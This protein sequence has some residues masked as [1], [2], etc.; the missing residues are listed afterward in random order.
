MTAVAAPSSDPVRDNGEWIAALTGGGPE[1]ER[2]T[3]TLR[4]TLRRALERAPGPGSGLDLEETTQEAVLQVLSSIERFRGDSAFTTWAIGIAIRTAYTELRRSSVRA[5]RTVAFADVAAE[6]DE[7][8]ARRPTDPATDAG[9]R[10][11]WAALDHAI[12]NALTDRQ[13][14]AILAEL[15]GIPT[16]EIA[17]QLQTNQNALYKLVHDARKKLRRDLERRGFDAS[18]LRDLAAKGASA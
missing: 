13:R 9:N 1:A 6:A 17:E 5:G 16:V 18:A 14:V 3:A 2:A 4:L 11:L 7:I 15:R 10:Q 12:A 8:G